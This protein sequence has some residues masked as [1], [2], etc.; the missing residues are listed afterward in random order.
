MSPG[1]VHFNT[2]YGVGT[3]QQQ[4]FCMHEAVCAGILWLLA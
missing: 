4:R 1:A 3:S 2:F